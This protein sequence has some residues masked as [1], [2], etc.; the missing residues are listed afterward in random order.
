M[1]ELI[2]SSRIIVLRVILAVVLSLV[3]SYSGIAQETPVYKD[4]DADVEVRVKDLL[5]RMT[6]EEKVQ[7]LHGVQGKGA[8]GY[9]EGNDRLGIP[10]LT[11]EDGPVGVRRDK[12][13]DF[14]ASLCMAATWDTD[15]LEMV[16]S[17]IGLETKSKGRS[18]LL[19]PCINILR[20]P[21]NG[22]TFEAYGEDP[23]L[24][25]RMAV[26]YI[27]GVQ[28]NNVIATPK[29]YAANNQEQDRMTIDTI[30]DE[31]TL[32]EIYFPA[33]RASIMEAGALS[34][35]PAYNKVNGS[36]CTEN[37]YLM[38]ELKKEWGFKGF[39]VSDWG[40]T[41]S[42]V[43]A[44]LAGLDVEMPGSTYFGD[45]LLQAVRDGKVRESIIN[46]K[47]SRV[48]RTMFTIGLFD[49]PITVKDIDFESHGKD[50][51]KVA[52]EGMVLLK[53]DNNILPLD[54]AK[55]KKLA[56]IGATA[57]NPRYFGGGSASTDP[58]YTVTPYDALIKVFKNINYAEG[59]LQD[60]IQAIDSE[61]LYTSSDGN[62]H[63]LKGEYY[64]NLDKPLQG[65]PAVVRIDENIDFNWGNITPDEKIDVSNFS[66]RWSGYLEVPETG[67]YTI[68]IKS[69]EGIRAILGGIRI[70]DEWTNSGTATFT[71]KVHLDANRLYP[72]I[73]EYKH[74]GS[75]AN[76]KLGWLM[77]D[78][79]ENLISEAVNAAKTADVAL[80]FVQDDQ[81]EG[82]DHGIVLPF[83][84]DEL[85]KAIAKVNLNTVVI[86][87]TGGPILMNDWINEVKGILEAWYGGQ[88]MGNAVTN[89]LTGKVNPS[90]RLP[91][92]FP[93]KVEDIPVIYYANNPEEGYPG[94][95]GHVK[96]T[97]GVYVGY[98]HYD[99]KNIKPLY[100]FGYG[101]TYTTFNY[102]DFKVNVDGSGNGRA[103]VV[104][105][106]TGAVEG[107][108]VVQLYKV[109]PGRDYKELISF[110]KTTLQP[111]QAKR[112]TFYIT[113][114]LLADYDKNL[115]YT[116]Q[117]GTYKLSVG[118]NVSDIKFNQ[119]FN[120]DNSL[121]L[122]K[123]FE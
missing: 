107:K 73:I 46:D 39:A 116:L 113:P 96:Y 117:S 26:S 66:V 80:V 6:L 104:V 79:I 99:A 57:K 101:L 67:E 76:V 123:H 89:L 61:Y 72:L 65:E 75:T 17:D 58:V 78:T 29:H 43:E 69:D 40:A 4:K 84:Q 13:T 27:K 2:V 42:T 52:E 82:R 37:E 70:I 1:R 85:I 63:G 54:P 118:P 11:M 87:N 25:S 53:N 28:S 51:L 74:Y 62:E 120:V 41:H 108:E 122:W 50:A 86:L 94:V 20:V 47:V 95:D 88:E 32:H 71:T 19:A 38:N 34:I 9:I 90:G 16:G 121:T 119:S 3:V 12:A 33:F 106:N 103:S 68:G 36:Y 10:P 14:P 8:T 55:I 111:G 18:M 48:L 102:S 7:M 81:T 115:D 35:M 112:I 24:V 110:K 98:R 91:A 64:N 109:S 77:P 49:N 21:M 60:G 44:A 97:E 83:N 105:Q 30:V 56:I 22:R 5:Q 100:P 59:F 92:T 45:A 23:Y 15:L 31:L 114:S 93:Y